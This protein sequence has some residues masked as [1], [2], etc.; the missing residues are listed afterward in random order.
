[1]LALV[2]LL[3]LDRSGGRYLQFLDRLA[4]FQMQIADRAGQCP[5]SGLQRALDFTQEVPG[6]LVDDP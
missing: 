5:A 6:M 1:V 4:D 3:R 2:G